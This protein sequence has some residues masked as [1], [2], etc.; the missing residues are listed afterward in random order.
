MPCRVFCVAPELS[1]GAMDGHQ[2]DP[3]DH[4]KETFIPKGASLSSA[5]SQKT[6]ETLTLNTDADQL[7]GPQKVVGGMIVLRSGSVLGG[8][9]EILR[10]LGVGGMGAVYK[11]RD[12]ELDRNVA[13]KV[14]RPELANQPEIVQRFKQE[15][16]LARQVTHK[17]VIRIFDLGEADGIKFIS[18]DYI[19]GQDLRSLLNQKGKFTSQEA[20]A[21]IVQVCQALEAAHSEGVVHRDLKPQNI[22]IDAQGKVTV[23]D[24]GIAHSAEFTGMTQ[25]GALLGTPEYM[26][27]EQ[28]KGLT[29]D[30]RSDVFTLGLIFYELLTG[31]TPYKGDNALAILLKRTQE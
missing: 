18:M 20:T 3:P 9:Y 6:A 17:N 29:A 19:E 24:F 11:A 15:L 12:S 4:D 23:M 7:L 8:R 22:M 25:T 1:G 13:L 14:I 5:D 2:K 16:I 26:S 30:S 28:A 27:P 21:I 10:Q 31:K